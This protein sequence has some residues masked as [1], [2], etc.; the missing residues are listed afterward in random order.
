M[1]GKIMNAVK[2]CWSSAM[3]SNTASAMNASVPSEPTRRRRKI[4]S[5]VVAVEECAQA[6]AGGVLDAELAADPGDQHGVGLDLALDLHQPGRERGLRRGE[7]RLGAG[8]AVSI[9]VPEGSMKV[10]AATVL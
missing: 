10:S 7:A 8:S 6:V 3:V 4:A 5:G 1:S 9:S 2:R